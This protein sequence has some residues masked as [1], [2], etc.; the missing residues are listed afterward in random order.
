LPPEHIQVGIIANTPIWLRHYFA[1]ESIKEEIKNIVK[2]KE[3]LKGYS[4]GHHKQ[5]QKQMDNR[6]KKL[7]QKLNKELLTKEWNNK[8]DDRWN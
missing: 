8:E 7:K 1:E 2:F 5:L 3:Q 4:C 6:I